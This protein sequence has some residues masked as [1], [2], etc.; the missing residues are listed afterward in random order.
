[1]RRPGSGAK[2]KYDWEE[3]RIDYVAGMTLCSLSKKYGLDRTQIS[4]RARQ[5]NWDFHGSLAT[6]YNDIAQHAATIVKDIIPQ[7]EKLTT[8][9]KK[10]EQNVRKKELDQA[11][12]DIAMLTLMKSQALVFTNSILEAATKVADAIALLAQREDLLYVASKRADG[13]VNYERITKHFADIATVLTEAGK[14]I[15]VNQVKTAV[16]INNPQIIE[17]NADKVTINVHGRE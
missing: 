15:G 13:S 8:L 5:F 3:I 7:D 10:L 14:I 6:Q 2:V 17:D 9:Q 11:Q 1:M 12:N 4:R 16:Q